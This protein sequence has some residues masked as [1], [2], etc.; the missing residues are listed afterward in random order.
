MFSFPLKPKSI[1][2][3][4]GDDNYSVLSTTPVL[5]LSKLFPSA[6][7]TSA[8]DGE[9][10]NANEH[11][12]INA[13]SS[14]IS[15][16]LPAASAS[17]T[18][19]YISMI[20]VES[21]VYSVDIGTATGDTFALG[22]VLVSRKT[23]TSGGSMNE[24]TTTTM[25]KMNIVRDANGDGGAGTKIECYFNGTNWSVSCVVERNGDNTVASTSDFAT[26]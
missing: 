11:Y 21:A 25:T 24:V 9:V 5:E 7:R 14:T 22:S 2:V 23:A 13:K 19:D 4:E 18:G 10:L 16:Q 17:T 3:K 15:L 6:A 12:T 8:A 20:F 26:S 1:Q